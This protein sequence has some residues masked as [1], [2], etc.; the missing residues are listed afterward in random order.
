MK[1]IKV[2]ILIIALSGCNVPKEE[3]PFESVD[4]SFFA[5]YLNSIKIYGSGQAL[6]SFN[7]HQWNEFYSLTLDKANLDSISNMVRVLSKIKIDSIYSETICDHCASFGLI[8]KSKE[9]TL[10][11]S[12]NG[13]FH[14]KELNSLFRLTHYLDNLIDKV[15][16]TADSIFVFESKS[17][18]ILPP[19]PPALP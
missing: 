5:G 12:Y 17:R 10:S 9:Y 18:L 1:L 16:K 2:L 6:I 14:E 13:E 11:T 3:T 4:Y 19:P 8:I 7:L 15:T